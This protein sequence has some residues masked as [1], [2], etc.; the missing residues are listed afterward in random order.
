MFY[1]L[2]EK[3]VK[4]LGGANPPPLYVR[5]LACDQGY[6]REEEY[7]RDTFISRGADRPRSHLNRVAQGV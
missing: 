2:W 3:S 1:R 4:I 6:F 7:A 5:G